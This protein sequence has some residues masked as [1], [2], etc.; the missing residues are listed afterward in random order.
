M[1]RQ[2]RR[3]RS[4]ARRALG[5][6]LVPMLLLGVAGAWAG[7]QRDQRHPATATILLNPLQ[8]NPFSPD[9]RDGLVNLETEARLVTSD[10]VARKVREKIDPTA[11]GT[12]LSSTL[13]GVKV[14]VP[15]NTQLLRITVNR[16]DAAKSRDLANAYATTYLDH[17]AGLTAATLSSQRTHLG[18]E[19]RD[20][21]DRLNTLT[22]QREAPGT[23]PQRKLLVEQQIQG[24]IA[25]ISQVQAESTTLGYVSQDPGQVVTPATMAVAGPV[26]TSVLGGAVG[27]AMGLALG[28]AVAHL[29]NRRADKI[30][31]RSDLEEGGYP[32]IGDTDD[33]E[34]LRARILVELPLRPAVVLVADA[35]A[36]GV[37]S[38]ETAR[39]LATSLG[40]AGIRHALLLLGRAGGRSDAVQVEVGPGTVD[41]TDVVK[42]LAHFDDLHAAG[43]VVHRG[44]LLASPDFDQ[45]IKNLRD[46]AELVLV[47]GVSL[48]GA[49]GHLLTAHADAVMVQA[50][51][52]L[53]TH[54]Q[55]EGALSDVERGPARLLGVVLNHAEA[56]RRDGIE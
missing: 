24:V 37:G 43:S 48:P 21:Q 51:A 1:A 4:T 23:S 54:A 45:M 15:A 16:A 44:D 49:D 11:A 34:V 27:A 36:D 50:D 53:T 25:Q 56:T 2:S 35:G 5:W 20:L 39:A 26:P 42:H 8:G 28:L 7:E 17:R 22:D 47:A 32:V 10:V 29:R 6:V 41:V 55:L 14:E 3:R 40:S 33:V 18:Q 46:H 38:V 31:G 30:G 9:A 12:D 13:S 19:L 52:G